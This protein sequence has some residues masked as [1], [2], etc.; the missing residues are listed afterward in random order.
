M[1]LAQTGHSRSST[2]LL[3]EEIKGDETFLRDFED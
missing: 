2:T 3:A 1:E